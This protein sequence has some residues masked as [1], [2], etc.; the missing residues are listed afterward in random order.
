MEYFFIKNFLRVETYFGTASGYFAGDFFAGETV[1]QD[2]RISSILFDIG[3][4]QLHLHHWLISFGV[5][6]FL[7]PFL[8]KR[9]EMT[10]FASLFFFGS[11]VGLMFQGIICYNDWNNV[12][13]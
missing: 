9:Y 13:K 6:L 2:G 12:I 11:L 10:S 1:G 5:L 8:N 4:F 7:F 3:T